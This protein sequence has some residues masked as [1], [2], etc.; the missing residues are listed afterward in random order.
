MHALLKLRINVP[1]YGKYRRLDMPIAISRKTPTGNA[2]QQT[3]A[4]DGTGK[5]ARPEQGLRSA[6]MPQQP[7]RSTLAYMKTV[8]FK[9]KKHTKMR[10][11]S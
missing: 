5:T 2:R 1:G 9:N 6:T 10:S 4:A 8:L 7:L 11:C 3:A